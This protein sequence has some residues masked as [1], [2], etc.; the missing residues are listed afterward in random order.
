MDAGHHVFAALESQR[1]RRSDQRSGDVSLRSP[2]NQSFPILETV[3]TPKR[4]TRA[5]SLIKITE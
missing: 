4:S 5:F 3:P 1:I 2:P